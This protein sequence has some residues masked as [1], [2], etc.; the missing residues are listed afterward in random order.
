MSMLSQRRRREDVFAHPH[1]NHLVFISASHAQPCP[2]NL[3]KCGVHQSGSAIV[4]SITVR[5]WCGEF[6]EAL[7]YCRSHTPGVLPQSAIGQLTNKTGSSVRTFMPVSLILKQSL[8]VDAL[9]GE[10][11]LSTAPSKE[12]PCLPTNF[13]LI[14]AGQ[15]AELSLRVGLG[16]L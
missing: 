3:R 13:V 8:T 9:S 10:T 15:Y 4:P 12:I 11:A 1:P 2:A 5:L 16:I 6:R 7:A 14:Q